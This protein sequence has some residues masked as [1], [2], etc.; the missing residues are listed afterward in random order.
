MSGIKNADGS[1]NV[2]SH[3]T[4]TYDASSRLTAE[5]LGGVTV[6]Y[7]YDARNQ[8]TNDFV[9]TY[10]Y[11]AGG[12]R[13]SN[14][15]SIGTGNRLNSDNDWTYTYDD[16]GN[17]TQKVS[18][19]MPTVTWTYAFDVS[20]RMSAAIKSGGGN[21][22]YA[23]TYSYD[24]FG[25]RIQEQEDADGASAGAAVTTRFALE[26]EKV[27]Q[28]AW[29]GRTGFVGMENWDVWA[30]LDGSNNIKVRYVR[31][32]AVD[33]LFSRVKSDGTVAWY[34][35]DRMGSV[36]QM[37]DASGA[38]QNTIS[39]DGFGNITSE[40][41]PAFGDRYKWT[42]REYNINTELQ[43]GR[44]RYFN[45]TTGN[46]KSEDKLRYNSNDYNLTSYVSNAP[47]LWVDP[48]GLLQDSPAGKERDKIKGKI[49]RFEE[50]IK[51]AE[52]ERRFS[53]YSGASAEAARFAFGP[54]ALWALRK[55][56]FLSHWIPEEEGRMH[57]EAENAAR[58]MWW[59]ANIALRHGARNAEV[60][61]DVHERAGQGDILDNIR[62]QQSN[63][64]G[65]KIA[66]EAEDEYNSPRNTRSKQEIIDD[67]VEARIKSRQ[68]PTRGTAL[69]QLVLGVTVY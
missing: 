14:G 28:D 9:K 6:S 51:Q 10:T 26:G 38:V 39:Y 37:T 24:V 58:H 52:R 36:R 18:I 32:D 57:E 27:S 12:N 40:S 29:G 60:I 43:F 2:L 19:A 59:Q 62:D 23:V 5:I 3:Y 65:R 56:K 34:Q 50:L 20:N 33:Q 49:A 8:L 48:S 4:Y 64:I 35:T 55:G 30:D 44:A 69:L 16:E 21:E 54:Y 45:S 63:V 17:L 68:F 31:G 53:V 67:K 41:A 15:G 42:G 22:L 7:D 47:T 11:D 25:N 1:S 13:T 46:W 66:A 61:G